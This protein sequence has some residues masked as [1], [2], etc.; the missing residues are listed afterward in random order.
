VRQLREDEGDEHD[1]WSGERGTDKRTMP[2]AFGVDVTPLEVSLEPPEHAFYADLEERARRVELLDTCVRE[3]AIPPDIGARAIDAAL[4]AMAH[5]AHEASLPALSHL[6][7]ALRSA[8]SAL[9][10]MAPVPSPIDVIVLDDDVAASDAIAIALEVRGH[11]VRCASSWEELLAQLG[12]R[13]PALVIA[14]IQ[15]GTVPPA[16]FCPTLSEVL[17]AA[18]VAFV[19]FSDLEKTALAELGKAHGALGAF[20]KSDGLEPWLDDA[21]RI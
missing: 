8:F 9:A 7:S 4:G 12:R 10:V 18:G 14:E 20:A 17:R 2:P 3:G 15:I 5:G 13:R 21:V 16:S 1:P 19:I 6:A 11:T